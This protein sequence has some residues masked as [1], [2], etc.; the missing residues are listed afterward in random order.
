MRPEHLKSPFTWKTRTI[1]IKDRIWYVPDY[2]NHY[3]MY[4]EF[5]F[6]G[7]QHPDIFENSNPICIEYCSGNGAWIAEKAKANPHLNWVAV[8]RK[9]IRVK[10]IWSK[11]QNMQLNNLFVI[12]GEGYKVTNHYFPDQSFQEV[13]INFPDPWPKC[14]HAKNRIVQPKFV[15]EMSRVLKTG[16]IATL[17][18]DDPDY[19][20]EMIQVMGGESSFSSL[21][22]DPFYR[23][24]LENY[25]SSYFEDL[26]REQG[27]HIRYHQY[28]KRP[29]DS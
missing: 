16:G 13:Y 4:D 9:F 18:T 10:K 19:S 29:S 1:L 7:W 3:E 25:G 11:I 21:Y 17:V 22:T 8:E 6:P 5:V 14:R 23:T 12:C 24:Q 26:W 15:K 27:K 2:Y 20:N 28:S